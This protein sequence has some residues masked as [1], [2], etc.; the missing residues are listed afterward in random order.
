MTI[1]AARS[2]L[3]D[4]VLRSDEQDFYVFSANETAQIAYNAGFFYSSCVVPTGL[5]SSLKP[6]IS[7]GCIIVLGKG[8]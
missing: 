2:K 4:P 6:L 5:V 3:G 7:S 1:E 8:R